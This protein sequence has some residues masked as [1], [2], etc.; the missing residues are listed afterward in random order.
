MS[1]AKNTN[2]K[3]NTNKRLKTSHNVVLLRDNEKSALKVFVENNYGNNGQTHYQNLIEK[4]TNKASAYNVVRTSH[5][6]VA[7]GTMTPT[8][9]LGLCAALGATDKFDQMFETHKANFLKPQNYK[10][11]HQLLYY[12]AIS[13]CDAIVSKVL[14]A[15]TPDVEKL[16]YN[17]IHKCCGVEGGTASLI[18]SANENDNLDVLKKIFLGLRTTLPPVLFRKPD[19]YKKDKFNSYLEKF[20]APYDLYLHSIRCVDSA[21]L[22]V[23]NAQ[24]GLVSDGLKMGARRYVF[25]ENLGKKEMQNVDYQLGFQDIEDVTENFKYNFYFENYN[26]TNV[27]EAIFDMAFVKY[28][29]SVTSLELSRMMQKNKKHNGQDK[30]DALN[31]KQVKKYRLRRVGIKAL[32]KS[33]DDRDAKLQQSLFGMELLGLLESCILHK[34]VTKR[35]PVVGNNTNFVYEQWERLCPNYD[36]NPVKNWIKHVESIGIDDEKR[37]QGD[38]SLGLQKFEWLLNILIKLHEPAFGQSDVAKIT[39][40]NSITSK[41][42]GG[43]LFGRFIKL[44]DDFFDPLAATQINFSSDY[45]IDRF[46][47]ASHFVTLVGIYSKAYEVLGIN[48]MVPSLSQDQQVA[49]NLFALLASEK[50]GAVKSNFEVYGFC[51][52]HKPLFY[53]IMLFAEGKMDALYGQEGKENRYKEWQGLKESAFAKCLELEVEEPKDELQEIGGGS[54]ENVRQRGAIDG[55]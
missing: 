24:E 14:G 16:K 37:Y 49:I 34:D 46:N 52:D 40:L 8:Q 41:I 5:G 55:R 25:L 10:A 30:N 48:N 42:F 50:I 31:K 35:L 3:N 27:L 9:K 15:N 20:Y 36:T 13:G 11:V 32:K 12:C 33:L 6:E 1:F 18:V 54:F 29:I 17:I 21:T 19:R 51:E 47:L 2:N 28:E 45:L 43:N 44:V 53:S 26:G 39:Q 38:F 23:L 22:D 4:I 7:I